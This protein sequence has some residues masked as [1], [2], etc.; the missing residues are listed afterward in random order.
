LWAL[1]DYVNAR[2]DDPAGRAECE[3]K[4][5]QFLTTRATPAAKVA[6]SRHLRVIAGDTAIPAL[7]A[8]LG[9][10]KSADLAIYVLQQMPGPAAGDALVRA[11]KTARG[12]VKTAV[13]VALGNR[14][15]AGA[16]PMLAPMLKDPALGVTAAMALARIGGADAAS[17]LAPAFAGGA[18]D[19]RR[20]IAGSVLVVA[21][22]L[23]A[24]GNA[25]Y[26]RKYLR[27]GFARRFTRDLFLLRPERPI[28]EL[29]VTETARAAGCPVPA[30]LACAVEDVGPF[31]RGWIVTEAI[32]P[33]RPLIDVLA[34]TARG[35]RVRILD[36][37]REAVESLHRIGVYHVD[38]TGHNVLVRDDLHP[39]ILDFDRARL[40][41]PAEPTRAARGFARL[42]RSLA[43]LAAAAGLELSPEDWRRLEPA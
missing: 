22:G 29:V 35:E 38:L 7:Q 28:H 24:G 17:L 3:A 15:A 31:Y 18:P 27:G 13:V 26:C 30:V 9:D 6:A 40:A 1:R 14:R 34:T 41:A 20:A 12:A 21:D 4:L 16:V 39:V 25:V 37:V 36:G 32:E 42:R 5:L 11:L 23:L 43:K 19:F 8:M 2:R 33:A 10:P